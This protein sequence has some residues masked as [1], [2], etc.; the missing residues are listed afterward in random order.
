MS[1]RSVSTS[2][3]L[4]RVL[5]MACL[6][7]FFSGCAPKF[8]PPPGYVGGYLWNSDKS[9]RITVKAGDTLYT[10]SRRYDVPT[11]VI[12]ARN[13]LKTPYVLEPG[14]QLILDPARVH[15]VVKG[16]SLSII[17][18][19]Y[20]I[21]YPLIAEVNDIDQPYTIYPGQ[22]LWIPDPFTIAGA[23]SLPP[24]GTIPR[25]RPRQTS[26]PAKAPDN[27]LLAQDTARSPSTTQKSS[28]QITARP[29]KP[30]TGVRPVP[31]SKPPP[32]AAS[33]FIWP[34]KGRLIAG[35]GPAGKGLHNDGINI[36]A[37]LGMQVRSADNGVVAYAGS[38]LKGFGYL[39]LIK[40]AQALTT[41]Y[42]HND[43]LLVSRGD[44]VKQ[45]QVVATV[46]KTGNVQVPQLHFEVRSG[47]RA[48]DPQEYLQQGG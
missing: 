40:H 9:R 20:G 41:A 28:T 11:R 24:R 34:V 42:A 47:T 39:L 5:L 19:A 45:G 25:M 30:A 35:F 10:I 38:E 32:R 16:E 22:E 21:D 23:A 12:I 31:I 29:S 13:G 33:R 17:A 14:Q 3:G 43:K 15:R 48:V 7:V 18:Q 8:E 27:P 1:L 4:P 6:V 36:A 26:P 46:G 37:P 44:I 2:K